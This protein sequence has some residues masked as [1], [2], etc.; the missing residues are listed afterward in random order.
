MND[1]S[2]T[3]DKNVRRL[4]VIKMCIDYPASADPNASTTRT[5]TL[6]Q[7]RKQH[8]QEQERYR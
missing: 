7:M 1:D 6:E 2:G 8:Q 5:G 3:K 4:C